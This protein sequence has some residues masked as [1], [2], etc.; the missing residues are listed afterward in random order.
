MKENDKELSNLNLQSNSLALTIV[1]SL[2][3]DTMYTKEEEDEWINNRQAYFAMEAEEKPVPTSFYRREWWEDTKFDPK[4][5]YPRGVLQT[6]DVDLDDD[7]IWEMSFFPECADVR[8]AQRGRCSVD[9]DKESFKMGLMA[10]VNAGTESWSLD[11][12]SNGEW[13]GLKPRAKYENMWMK[14]DKEIIQEMVKLIDEEL[15]D[16]DEWS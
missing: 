1:T 3:S 12:I 2:W 8:H 6:V 4:K 16:D 14:K 9:G 10:Y 15:G 11:E 13:S 5:N 7:E